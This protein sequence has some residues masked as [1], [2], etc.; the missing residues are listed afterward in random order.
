MYVQYMYSKCTPYI[1]V[2][3]MPPLLVPNTL[4]PHRVLLCTHAPQK[5]FAIFF[6]ARGTSDRRQIALCHLVTCM[7]RHSS[8]WYPLMYGV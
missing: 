6:A 7:T 3:R 1:R 5:K 2:T 4:M 8:L